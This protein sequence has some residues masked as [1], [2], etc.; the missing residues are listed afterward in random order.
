MKKFE[1]IKLPIG[2]DKEFENEII[3]T[4]KEGSPRLTLRK[5]IWKIFGLKNKLDVVGIKV[6]V[7]KGKILIERDEDV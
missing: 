1:V 3:L 4:Y 6:K 7:S 5:E 2:W